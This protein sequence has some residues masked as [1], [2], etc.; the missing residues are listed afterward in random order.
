MRLFLTHIILFLFFLP[1]AFG[2]LSED[3]IK[4]NFIL[5]LAIYVEWEKEDTID[6]F[7]MGVL[8]G[9]EIYEAL[10]NRSKQIS[11]KGKAIDIVQ[12]KQVN[13]IRNVHMLYVEERKNYALKRILDITIANQILMFS[14]SCA[15]YENIMINLLDLD[16]PGNQFEINKENLKK[17]SFDVNRVL[18][19]LGGTEEDLREMYKAS[20]KELTMVQEELEQQMAALEEQRKELDLKKREVL[21]L[22]KEI[23]QQERRL[24]SMIAEANAKQDSLDQKIAL[25]NE[26]KIKIREQQADIDE[27]SSQLLGQR[28]EI[29]AGNTFLNQQKK[30]IDKQEQRLKSQQIEIQAQ[31]QTLERQGKEIEDQTTQIEKQRTILY[32]FI[33]FFVL[34]AGMIFSILR[35]YR[36]KRQANQQL[37]EKNIAI[38]RQKEEIQAQQDQ[39]KKI[40]RKIEKQNENIKSSIHYALTIQQ[41]LM[42]SKETLDKEFDSFIVYRPKDIVSGDFYWMCRIPPKYNAAEKFFLVLADCTGHGVPGAFLSLI[43]IKLLSSIINERKE[44]D[45]KTILEMLNL[46]IQQALQQ[47]KIG[48][49]DGMDVCLCKVEK[50][51][52]GQFNL[53]YSGAKRPLYYT[54]N[55][56]INILHGDRKTVGGRF[57]KQQVFT[58]QALVLNPGDRIYLSSDGIADQ[59]A[60][61]RQKFGSKRLIKLLEESMHL[62]MAK[63]KEAL[64]KALDA[65]QQQ[66]KQRDDISLMAIKF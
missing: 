1:S 36:I 61:N 64:E 32:F 65:F 56:K 22:N 46:D 29:E 34:I 54:K 38:T 21:Q 17:A 3:V 45:P 8:G 12:F 39:L 57:F 27:Q 6:H 26:Q 40:N 19:Y 53:I 25:L 4:A 28:Q 44:Y 60:P 63:Q 55:K 16:L 47:E 31:T 9:N 62:P 59:N 11:F 2:Q 20:E 49:D 48:S 23:G 24:E 33:A 13:E 52:T 66:E 37:E 50:T 30:E 10:Q 5:N 15:D 51:E 18:V 58:N 35:A 42:P 7:K 41:A 43:G 14:D